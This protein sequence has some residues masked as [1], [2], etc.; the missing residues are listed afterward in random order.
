MEKKDDDKNC[1]Y[2]VQKNLKSKSQTSIKNKKLNIFS[3]ILCA[4]TFYMYADGRIGGLLCA[5][6]HWCQMAEFRAA[7]PKNGPVKFLAA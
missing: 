3:C 2:F 4:I 1:I 5:Y 6:R 7:R